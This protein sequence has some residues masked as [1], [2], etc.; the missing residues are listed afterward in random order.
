MIAGILGPGGNGGTFLDWT[1][2]WLCGQ[3]E[4]SIIQ[5][6]RIN[7][8]TAQPIRVDLV[9]DP[10][11]KR[12]AHGHLKTH[13]N[14]ETLYRCI[15]F[16]RTLPGQDLMSFYYVASLDQSRRHPNHDEIIAQYPDVKF[17]ESVFDSDCVHEIFCNQMEKIPSCV[18]GYRLEVESKSNKDLSLWDLR[19][20]LSLYYPGCIKNQ[21]TY[22]QHALRT[23]HFLL[24]HHDLCDN[25]PDKIPE[26]FDFLCLPLCPE[27]LAHWQQVW[28]RWSVTNSRFFFRDLP[29]IID[30]ILQGIYKDLSGH[31]MTFAKEIVIASHLLFDHDLALRS[32][33]LERIKENTLAWHDILEPNIYHDLS[34]SQSET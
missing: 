6:D 26:L 2:H 23:N 13:P 29:E 24:H 17:I 11:I 10:L 7:N 15:E 25:M 18:E 19:E 28:Q 12:T 27:R 3:R 4:R 20:A 14:N 1:L 30:C 34:Q 8:Q 32:F 33:G 21:L 31:D 9:S 22:R 5:V 16:F